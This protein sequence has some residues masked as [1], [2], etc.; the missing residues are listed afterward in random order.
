MLKGMS[1]EG[2]GSLAVL[3]GEG[4]SSG[5]ERTAAAGTAAHLAPVPLQLP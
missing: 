2:M 1:G 4:G 5:D 3:E